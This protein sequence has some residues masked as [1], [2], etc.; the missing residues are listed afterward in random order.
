[1]TK[2][3]AVWQEVVTV[4]K[5][6]QALS[7]LSV[8]TTSSWS[9][10][11]LRRIRLLRCTLTRMITKTHQGWAKKQMLMLTKSR[12]STP[13]SRCNVCMSRTR[14]RCPRLFSL[15]STITWKTRANRSPRWASSS[16]FRSR[17][18]MTPSEGTWTQTIHSWLST[19]WT[20][21]LHK[22]ALELINSSRW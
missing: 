12:L 2:R 21:T 15:H 10:S 8:T 22:I 7:V 11:K 18:V 5:P 13:T 9:R 14:K 1:M 3:F 20:W 19:Q 17:C 16:L 6:R 4:G